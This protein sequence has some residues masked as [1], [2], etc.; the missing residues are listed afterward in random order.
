MARFVSRRKTVRPFRAMRKARMYRSVGLRKYGATVGRFIGRKIS[1]HIHTFRKQV[2]MGT[3]VETGADQHL[4]Y[5]FNLDQLS[6]ETDFQSMYD[7][8]KIKKIILHMEPVLTASNTNNTAPFNYRMRIVHDY[9]D[10][11]LL[12]NE[13]Q[14]LQYGNCRSVLVASPRVVNI[15]LYPK[16]QQYTQSGNGTTAVFRA[17]KAGWIPTEHDLVQHLGLKIFLP[18]LGLT[19]GNGIFRLRATFI[20]Q[21]KNS[22]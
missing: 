4:G 12:A 16:I 5:Q 9:D 2:M 1:N 17:V 7:S 10:I 15:P 21:F 6:D 22:K 8:Y 18:T 19:Q 11:N 14:Y 3:L 13:N 20:V